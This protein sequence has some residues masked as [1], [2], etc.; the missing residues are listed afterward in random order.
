MSWRRRI[1][2]AL[3]LIATV[4]TL[5]VFSFPYE[6]IPEALA[7]R[8]EAW[9][10]IAVEIEELGPTISWEGIGVEARQARLTPPGA[11]PLLVPRLFIRPSWTLGWLTGQ[12]RL[13]VQLEGG[14]LGRL[15]GF[16]GLGSNGGWQTRLDDIRLDALPLQLMV[17]GLA[18][19]GV[20]SGDIDL[21]LDELGNPQGTVAVVFSDGDLSAPG[22]PIALPFEQLTSDI[23]F[24]GEHLATVQE[25]SVRGPLLDA[26]IHGTIAT[27]PRRGSE[28]LSLTMEL[29]RV[30]PMLQP[31]LREL[32]VPL[33]RQG[34]TQLEI[35]GTLERP[36]FR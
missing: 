8:S 28:P 29:D 12:P 23:L 22:L 9:T 35:T 21:T 36:T 24:G 14:E 33:A 7:A 31:F 18:M 30:G 15:E 20:L 17:P 2:V 13:F 27:A 5:V 1:A 19:S 10:G 6:R 25:L 4:L 32:D 34:T 26:R 3:A 11:A 16:A